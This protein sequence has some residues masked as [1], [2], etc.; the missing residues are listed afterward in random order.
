MSSSY[1]LCC[2]PSVKK[3]KHD[4]Y[5]FRL[6]PDNKTIVT[7]G[8][9]DVQNNQGL[10]KRYQHNSY[11][12]TTLINLDITKTS[13]I[14][15]SNWTDWSTIQG[16]IERV[17][18]KSD[19]DADLKSIRDYCL[20]RGLISNS[21][22]VNRVW[23]Q[24]ELHLIQSC[25]F[26]MR[27]LNFGSSIEESIHNLDWYSYSVSFVLVDRIFRFIPISSWSYRHY[28]CCT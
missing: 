28:S 6:M 15:C 10:G 23:L 27:L 1:A 17:I 19:E 26:N 7:F 16:V 11:L 20:T 13:S 21:F 22:L 18:W 3:G 9:C 4:F 8:F 5:F 14:Y 24:T 25:E 12:E 2:L